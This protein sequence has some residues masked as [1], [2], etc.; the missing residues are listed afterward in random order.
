MATVAE[1]KFGS[2]IV[3][4]RRVPAGRTASRAL[5][6]VVSVAINIKVGRDT[7]RTTWKL[8][9]ITSPRSH[10]PEFC[11]L[12]LEPRALSPPRLN[13]VKHNFTYAVNPPLGQK[14]VF[15]ATMLRERRRVP[16]RGS[17]GFRPAPV[18]SLP[19]P[20]PSAGRV[21]RVNKQ[22]IGRQYIPFEERNIEGV[23]ETE[24]KQHSQRKQ[25]VAKVFYPD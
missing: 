6:V 21:G 25:D 19:D 22:D 16:K 4:W 20:V 24:M 17:A 2:F 14:C 23:F 15:L 5:A 13:G 7:A 12:F 8:D 10:A 1:E 18:K 11:C 9:F 3:H